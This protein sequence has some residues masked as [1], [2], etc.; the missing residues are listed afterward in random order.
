MGTRG[1]IITYWLCPGEPARGYCAA[2]IREL[3]ARF[4][5]PVFEPHVTI[6][7]MSAER[8]HPAE[9]L[10]KVLPGHRRFRLEALGLGYSDKFT[11]TLFIR[12]APHPDLARLS[13]DLRRAS[14][15]P[16]D[17]ELNPHLSLLYKTMDSETKREL[18]RSIALPF[19]DATF[20]TVKAVLSP[21]RIESRQDVESWRVV[22]EERLA[23]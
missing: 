12:F 6:F 1:E 18:A 21:A 3:A 16:G 13:E 8:G 15:S 9:V 5:A 23:R 4:D 14:G 10:A 19:G 17:Y 22:A 11:E 7:V 2:L 20:D